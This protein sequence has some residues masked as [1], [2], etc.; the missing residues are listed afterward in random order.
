M[1][2]FQTKPNLKHAIICLVKKDYD[3]LLLFSFKQ[4]SIHKP[5]RLFLLLKYNCIIKL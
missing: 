1:H 4:Y 3:F 2:Q 5:P